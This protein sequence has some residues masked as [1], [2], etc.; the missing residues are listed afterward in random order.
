MKYSLLRKPLLISRLKLIERLVI[1]NER[2]NTK[3]GKLLTCRDTSVGEGLHME[4]EIAS[5]GFEPLSWCSSA[6]RAGTEY[7]RWA[8]VDKGLHVESVIAFVG[9]KPL[10]W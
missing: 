5:I 2:T 3:T 7:D 1:C 4:N 8:P 6:A 9:F 10:S